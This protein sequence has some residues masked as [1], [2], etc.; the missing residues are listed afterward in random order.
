MMLSNRDV[1]F[2]FPRIQSKLHPLPR[3]SSLDL[4]GTLVFDYPTAAE[5]SAFIMSQLPPAPVPSSTALPE[6]LQVQAQ[7]ALPSRP[8]GIVVP[9]FNGAIYHMYRPN[10]GLGASLLTAKLYNSLK[11]APPLVTFYTPGQASLLMMML[12]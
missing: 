6:P 5:L 2:A 7:A 9:D 12:N 8:Q 4:P 10:T 11:R 1:F 3:G